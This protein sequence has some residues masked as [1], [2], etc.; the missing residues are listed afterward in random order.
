MKRIKRAITP[1]WVAVTNTMAGGGR[2]S[3]RGARIVRKTL[4]AFPEAIIY[5]VVEASNL[6]GVPRSPS[7][8]VD[9]WWRPDGDKRDLVKIQSNKDEG[10]GNVAAIIDRARL[11]VT[12]HW[13]MPS[14]RPFINGRR[15]KMRVRYTLY[16][17]GRV[18]GRKAVRTFR[19]MHATPPRWP[20]LWRASIRWVRAFGV[21][22]AD[23]NASEARVEE[24]TGKVAFLIGV[25]GVAIPKRWT[26]VAGHAADVDGD[27]KA[28]G[29]KVRPR[30]SKR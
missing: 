15:I 7:E 19:V 23:W 27:H 13:L 30:A 25:L 5:G 29:A 8:R 24:V 20:T 4:L 22:L 16:V 21:D 3:E 18:D 1:F 2:G 12:R 11:D 14:V 9:G 10:R 17:R 6:M 26:L 28:V